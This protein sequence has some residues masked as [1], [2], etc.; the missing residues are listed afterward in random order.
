[1]L[2]SS[3]LFKSKFSLLNWV[4]WGNSDSDAL[5]VLVVLFFV[6]VE[7]SFGSFT[8]SLVSEEV[9][10]VSPCFPCDDN[11]SNMDHGQNSNNGINKRGDLSTIGISSLFSSTVKTGERK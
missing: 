3:K 1:L 2:K 7:E 10:K 6:M 5:V 8:A 9:S 4:A 11:V